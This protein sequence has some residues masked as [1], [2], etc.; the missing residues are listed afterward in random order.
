M[1]VGTR[2]DS[3]ADPQGSGPHA[4][5]VWGD[6]AAGRDGDA[7]GEKQPT[8]E[9]QE[10]DQP[11]AAEEEVDVQAHVAA[12]LTR[13]MAAAGPPLTTEALEEED[14]RTMSDGAQDAVKHDEEPEIVGVKEAHEVG[15][16]EL[17]VA[18]KAGP[19]TGEVESCRHWAKGWCMQADA[20][21]Y[22]RPQPP[23]PQGVPQDLLLIL[24][25][26]ARVG[27]LGLSRSQSLSRSHGT[28]MCEVVEKAQ[29]GGLPAVG[30]AVACEGQT[31]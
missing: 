20:C 21:R 18:D 2:L 5:P 17:R 30:Y 8:E 7:A 10:Q 15:P 11:E 28:L 22:A 29:G 9:E 26:M 4:V 6:E 3:G 1:V 24:Q 13:I 25:A 16:Q 19:K 14:Q 27:A 23:V 31:E 12:A